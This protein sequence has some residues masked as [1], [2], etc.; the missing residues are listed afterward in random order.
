[1]IGIQRSGRNQALE[2][3]PP[4]SC[5]DKAYERPLF[6]IHLV[7]HIFRLF[8]MQSYSTIIVATDIAIFSRPYVSPVIPRTAKTSIAV[9]TRL[10]ANNKE[11]AATSVSSGALGRCVLRFCSHTRDAKAAYGSNAPDRA[12]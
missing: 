9:S 12:I 10:S 11:F 4:S 1:M 7:K 3:P 6:T 8:Y 2:H 5:P